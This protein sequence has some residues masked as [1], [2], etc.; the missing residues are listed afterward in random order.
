MDLAFCLLKSDFIEFSKK[1]LN[2][3]FRSETRFQSCFFI[4]S[5]G[6]G[7]A[8]LPTGRSQGPPPPGTGPP[9]PG[10]A[11]PP[12]APITLS[13][14]PGGRGAPVGPLPPSRPG[15]PSTGRGAQILAPGNCS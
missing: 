14:P 6:R 4:I 13:A 1:Y 15:P 8:I 2:S 5:G 12:S 7:R 9:A 3:R 11:G 10:R